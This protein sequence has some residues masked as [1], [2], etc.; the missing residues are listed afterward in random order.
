MPTRSTPTTGAKCC[1]P[2][3]SRP[4]TSPRP[5]ATTNTAGD[6]DAWSLYADERWQLGGGLAATV[7]L[8][9]QHKRYRFAQQPVG[10]FSGDL[11]NAYTVTDRFFNPKAALDWNVPGR[12]AGGRLQ[13]YANAGIN[14]REPTDGELFDTWTGGDDLGAVPLF[15]SRREV[16]DG[17]G[18]IA[19]VE[20]SDPLVRPERVVDRE[21]GVGWRGRGAEWTLGGYWMDFTDEIV[22]YGGV[23]SDGSSIRG[24]AGRTRHRGLEL[25]ARARLGPAHAVALAASRSWDEAVEFIFHDWDGSVYDYAGNPL[26]LFPALPGDGVLGRRLGRRPAQPGARAQHRPAVAGQFGAGRADHRPLDD[27]RPVPVAGSARSGSD[28]RQRGHGVRAPAQP[29]RH[30]IRNLGLLVRRELADAGGGTQRRRRDRL[31]VLMND[32][33]LVIGG[34]GCPYFPKQGRRAVVLCDGP[35]PSEAVL[36]YWLDGA[37]LF[38]CADAAGHPYDHLPRVPDVVIG[39]FDSLSGRVLAGRGGPRFLRVDDPYTTDS[40]KALLYVC[41]AGCEEAV[42]LGATGWRLDHTLFNVQLL[43]RF[44]DRLRDVPGRLPGR[45]RARRRRARTWRGSCPR[46]RASRCCRWRARRAA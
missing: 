11:L 10:N 13:V 31:R 20:W 39:D 16:P 46:A 21:L 7:N 33:D 2:T 32:E 22:P 8:Q 3:G 12:V 4:R 34:A 5:G 42:L 43:E 36:A 38:V 18:G 23:N 9:Y 15:A 37:D 19:Y 40:E 27:G 26:A 1:G 17:N 41:D 24:N 35:P 45:R 30:R 14:H 28:P 29:G 25:S 6:K 44:S